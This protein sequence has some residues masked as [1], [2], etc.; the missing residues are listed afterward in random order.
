MDSCLAF[1]VFPFT[2]WFSD[3]FIEGV[4]RDLPVAQ[5]PQQHQCGGNNV[6]GVQ[7]PNGA[8]RE[9]E[10]VERMHCIGHIGGGDVAYA[11]G[12]KVL[13]AH[14]FEEH[15]QH[16]GGEKH[17]GNGAGKQWN[18]HNAKLWGQPV[19]PRRQ[20]DAFVCTPHGYFCAP[21]PESQLRR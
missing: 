9:V 8:R 4:V 15:G 13:G 20:K 7:Q 3:M 1:M 18:V 21:S 14:S 5:A 2:Y 10:D 17:C 19:P 6:E 12:L 11:V 16:A